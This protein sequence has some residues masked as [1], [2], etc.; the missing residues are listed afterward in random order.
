[1]TV[2]L[3]PAG[4]SNQEQVTDLPIEKLLDYGVKKPESQRAIVIPQ[5]SGSI[6]H[7]YAY[8]G[9]HLNFRAVDFYGRSRALTGDFLILQ[10]MPVGSFLVD[11]QYMLFV[12]EISNYNKLDSYKLQLRFGFCEEGA[13]NSSRVRYKDATV[14]FERKTVDGVP[15]DINLMN[16]EVRDCRRPRR[17]FTQNRKDRYLYNAPL[18]SWMPDDYRGLEA[19]FFVEI[20]DSSYDV[21]WQMHMWYSWCTP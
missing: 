19:E 21:Q 11:A 12:E 9:D 18:K 10:K 17:L 5:T 13:P 3:F 15:E 8:L 6:R 7:G 4:F 20:L 1:M 2:V 16:E 14:M